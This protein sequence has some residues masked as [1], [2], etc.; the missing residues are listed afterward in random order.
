[1]LNKPGRSV[2]GVAPKKI[3]SF[4]KIEVARLFK[5]AVVKVRY[6]GVRILMTPLLQDEPHAKLLLVVPKRTGTAPERNRIKRRLRVIFK[7]EGL[8][9]GTHHLTVIVDNRVLSIP[10]EK[11]KAL[12]LKTQSPVCP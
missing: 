9:S 11:L 2:P 12:V 3:S 7:N 5:Q 6:P 8:F 10:F 4:S 1:M